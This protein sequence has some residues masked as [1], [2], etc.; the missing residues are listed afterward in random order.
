[1]DRFLPD[2]QALV[3][4]GAEVSSASSGTSGA[5]VEPAATFFRPR[6]GASALG[7]DLP[8]SADTPTALPGLA[9]SPS[10]FAPP[11]LRFGATLAAAAASLASS[12]FLT[13]ATSRGP[14][15]HSRP[16]TTSPESHSPSSP[17]AGHCSRPPS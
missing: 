7:F 15:A 11:R 9:A 5:S 12:A 14:S 13:S 3:A 17:A 6:P 8:G 4:I 2:D 1:P 16:I 10:T